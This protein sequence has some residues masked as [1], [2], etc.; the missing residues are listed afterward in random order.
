MGKTEEL[1]TAWPGEKRDLPIKFEGA[2]APAR[3]FVEYWQFPFASIRSAA[4]IFAFEFMKKMPALSRPWW[5]RVEDTKQS[6]PL[7]SASYYAMWD[8]VARFAAEIRASDFMKEM[9]RR[10]DA[11]GSEGVMG[12]LDCATLYGLTRWLRPAVVVESGGFIGMSSAFILKA[13][14]DEKLA[15]AKLYSIELSPECDH[16]ALIPDELRSTSDGFVPMRGKA[17]DFLKRNEIPSV[18][19]M[20]LHDSSHSY[21]HMLWEFRQFWPRLRDG[22]LLVSHDVQMNAAFPEFV[23]KTYSHDKKTGRRDAQRTSHHE[24][25]RWGYIGFA[26]KKAVG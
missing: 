22:G 7:S 4:N 21:R 15:T 9:I 1:S 18:I 10:R 16:G 6:E 17:E 8:T 20:F 25:G 19:D 26:I 23:V 3:F 24:W 13:F 11:C 2:S 12:A 5:R 14:A